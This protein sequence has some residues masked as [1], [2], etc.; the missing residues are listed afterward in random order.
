MPVYQY[1]NRSGSI[2]YMYR[3]YVVKF[4]EKVQIKRRGFNTKKEAVIAEAQIVSSYEKF[5]SRSLT[6]NK[7][8]EEYIQAYKLRNKAQSIRR[9]E[10]MF[11]LQI[12]PYFS[13]SK[14]AKISV[15]DYMDWQERILSKEY[16][17]GYNKALH[18]AMVSIFKYAVKNYGLSNNIP[19]SVGG[20]KKR[21]I[22]KKMNVWSYEE[23]QKFINVIED[24][25]DYSIFSFLYGTGVRFGEMAALTFND[26]DGRSVYI[27]KT[28]SKE[29][30][31]EGNYVVNT[32]K[33]NSSER[34]VSLSDEVINNINE[35][36]NFWS[37]FEGFNNQ[38]FI[39]GGLRPCSH[40]TI[41]RKKNEYC[42][43]AGVK[44][45]KLHEFRHSHVSFLLQQQVP[46]TNISE[47]VGHSNSQITLSI[48]SHMLESENDPVV[49]VLN[50]IS[51][52]N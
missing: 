15:K 51:K 19:Q 21:N 20:F 36:K 27:N 39:F 43:K 11:R 3:T 49:D 41:T 23:Y 40:T 5:T 24:K 8:Y 44:Q 26:Y 34:R 47:R 17:D 28:I 37:K 31:D 12:L 16:S 46:I 10:S 45:I 30:D 18:T 14:V 9:E 29:L 48:Y 33:T 42:K 4:G 1:K 2:K 52:N 13:N 32:P 50:N 6:F 7:L 22:K 25:V 35:L 38:W